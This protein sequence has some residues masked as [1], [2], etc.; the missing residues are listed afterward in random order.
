MADKVV[1]KLRG[2]RNLQ[3]SVS[4]RSLFQR[5]WRRRTP[6]ANTIRSSWIT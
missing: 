4:D 6:S 2:Q 3:S 5:L 1:E